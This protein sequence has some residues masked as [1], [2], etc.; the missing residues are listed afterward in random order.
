[1]ITI[2]IWISIWIAIWMAIQTEDVPVY[3]GHSL[4]NTT[5]RITLLFIVQSLFHRNPPN[6]WIK[7]TKIMI[8][9]ERLHRTKFLDPDNDL[10]R[11]LNSFA[12]CKQGNRQRQEKTS[13]YSTQ[14]MVGPVLC[15]PIAL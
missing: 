11:N 3:T 14:T 8:Q 12:L 5:M 2:T 6:I 1:M 9:I 4:F 15:Y 7:I 10:V 13:C